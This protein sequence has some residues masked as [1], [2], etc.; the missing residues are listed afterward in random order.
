MFSAIVRKYKTKFDAGR[1]TLFKGGQLG[2]TIKNASVPSKPGVYIVKGKANGIHSVLYIGMAGTMKSD[3][4]FKKQMLPSRLKALQRW[5]GQR[6]RRNVFFQ[7][8]MTALH[9]QQ[10]VFEWFVTF[11]GKTKVIPA[12]AE[13]QLLQTYFDDYGAL[14]AWNHE[15]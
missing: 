10:L 3:G 11:D 4:T 12:Y 1:F 7:E 5:K 6:V 8:R 15:M 2:K 9:M 13:S 14:P